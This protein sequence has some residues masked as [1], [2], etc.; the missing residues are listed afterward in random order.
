MYKINGGNINITQKL[1]EL[2]VVGY[3]FIF[4]VLS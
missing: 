2:N 3:F 4:P 1:S